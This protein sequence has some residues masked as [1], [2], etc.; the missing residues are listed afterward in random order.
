VGTVTVAKIVGMHIANVPMARI[1]NETKTTIGH[2]AQVLVSLGHIEPVVDNT[3]LA[4]HIASLRNVGDIVRFHRRVGSPRQIRAAATEQ[5]IRVDVSP[6]Q[7]R[8]VLLF[9]VAR[10][11]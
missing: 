3:S 2:V 8:G 9:R 11:E 7:K 5:G 4:D 10:I 1:A 6:C